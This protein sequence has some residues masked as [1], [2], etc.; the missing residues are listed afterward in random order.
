MKKGLKCSISKHRLIHSLV[1]SDVL[2]MNRSDV[3]A[4][5]HQL[6]ATDDVGLLVETEHQLTEH[7]LHVAALGSHF[8]FP[9][10]LVIENHDIKYRWVEQLLA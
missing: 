2:K 6:D 4:G 10:G 8:G 5:F 9:K 1:Y 3:A 7:P